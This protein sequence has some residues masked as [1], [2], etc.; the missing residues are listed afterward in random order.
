M[1]T[2]QSQG[3][4]NGTIHSGDFSEDSSRF[5]EN[6]YSFICNHLVSSY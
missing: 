5:P 2:G 6:F 4:D 1:G 3:R